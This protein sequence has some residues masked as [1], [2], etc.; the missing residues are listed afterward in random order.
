MS[1]AWKRL[2]SDLIRIPFIIQTENGQSCWFDTPLWCQF[3]L[4]II[5]FF[6]KMS[7]IDQIILFL[8]IS[9]DLKARI[10][11]IFSNKS[12][13]SW[14]FSVFSPLQMN[15]KHFPVKYFSE[16][17]F[18]GKQHNLMHEMKWATETWFGYAQ[19]TRSSSSLYTLFNL[20]K[21]ASVFDPCSRYI[22]LSCFVLATCTPNKCTRSM[23][24]KK[25]KN[26]L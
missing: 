8:L 4:N 21:N 25:K 26:S 16:F 24:E 19:K 3:A 11:Y 6:Y 17:F 7:C 18:S 10:L 9:S 15:S 13:H 14:I 5:Y 1:C 2:H 20:C 23:E 22:Y 12:K